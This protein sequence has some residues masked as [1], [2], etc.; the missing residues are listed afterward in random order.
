MNEKLKKAMIIL[1]GR[2]E[3]HKETLSECTICVPLIIRD[4]FRLDTHL[5]NSEGYQKIKNSLII[6]NVF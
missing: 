4:P 3:E 6:I 5:Y 2:A 1:N